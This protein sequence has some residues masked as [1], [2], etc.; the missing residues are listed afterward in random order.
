MTQRILSIWKNRHTLELRAAVAGSTGSGQSPSCRGGGK[1]C[2][3]RIPNLQIHKI[4]C[5][6]STTVHMPVCSSPK[7]STK[8]R[9]LSLCLWVF[10]FPRRLLCHVRLGLNKLDTLSSCY[11]VFCCMGV[12]LGVGDTAQQLRI[13][14]PLLEH[15]VP[16][17]T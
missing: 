3:S 5:F 9:Q 16:A 4:M 17:P 10:F 15:Q 7:L 13:Y 14:S 8:T 2:W 6:D 12:S 11:P 1:G